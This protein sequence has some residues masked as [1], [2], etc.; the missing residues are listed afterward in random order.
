VDAFVFRVEDE[1]SVCTPGS[2][3][4]RNSSATTGVSS[5]VRHLRCADATGSVVDLAISSVVLSKFFKFDGLL[6]HQ[7]R[8]AGQIRS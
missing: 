2:A 1:L 6:E 5:F 8:L 7:P 4:E 3:T